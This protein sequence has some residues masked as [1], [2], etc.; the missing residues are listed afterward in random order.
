MADSGSKS[1]V[2]KVVLTVF[3]GV[4]AFSFAVM[5]TSDIFSNLSNRAVAVVGGEEIPIRQF[6][7]E[8]DRTLR[9]LSNDR[10]A[11]ISATQAAAEG[12]DQQ[13]LANMV[14]RQTISNHAESLGVTASDRQVI[15]DIK[16]IDA[17]NGI[18]NEFDE[19]TFVNALQQSGF[20]RLDFEQG[21]RRD[22]TRGQIIGAIMSGVEIPTG[23]AELIVRNRLE[24]RNASYI[25]LSPDLAGQIDAPSDEELQSHYEGRLLSYTAPERRDISFILVSP[26]EFTADVSI[27]DED[28][29][30][31]Y[32]FRIESFTTPEKR[33][34]ERLF[35]SEE[36]MKAAKVRI[37][38]GESFLAVGTSLGL[39]QEEIELGKIDIKGITD[40]V[41]AEAAF[42]LEAPGLVGPIQ[43]LS[44]ALVRVSSIT[45]GN[46]TPFEVVVEDLREELILREAERSMNDHIESI[47]EDISSGIP[48]EDIAERIGLALL[49]AKGV[50]G[51]GEQRNGSK[52]SDLP[53][54][55]ELL[56]EAFASV[57][58]FDSDL[59]DFGQN[60]YFVVRVDEIYQSQPKE[61]SEVRQQVE[62]EW[63]TQTRQA[64]LLSLAQ[65]MV[66]RANAGEDF[67]SLASEVGRGVLKAPEPIARTQITDLFSQ[68][69]LFKLF[70]AG[71]G[72]YFFSNIDLGESLVVMRMDSVVGVE[73]DYVEPIIAAIKEQL[74]QGLENDTEQLYF[75]ALRQ[76]YETKQN[77]QA[78]E[79]A[80]GQT[81]PAGF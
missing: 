8:Y 12:I 52:A 38:A 29:K 27:P 58:N 51:E 28:V 59:I 20:S 7:A 17:F 43:G 62:S 69:L 45:E 9:R 78:I 41:A 3:L 81:A 71:Q 72:Q 13:V 49:T 40:V 31:L 26:K 35:G 23:M 79:L 68:R 37:E 50:T 46:V 2:K 6:Q 10:G 5:G 53:E 63:L 44:W 75:N 57:K 60:E 56:K 15:K 48:L 18:L 4:I 21:V 22:I 73:G 42:A 47:D 64:K 1:F 61:F 74:N 30:D 67:N 70:D 55:P 14:L 54:D 33:T 25:V 24:R 36:D 11:R 34:V 39:T 19:T 80:T 65:T 76:T 16:K 66:T 32:E 77:T